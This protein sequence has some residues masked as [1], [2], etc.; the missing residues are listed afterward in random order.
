MVVSIAQKYRD[1]GV[2]LE[3]LVMAGFVGLLEGIDRYDPEKNAK[4]STY[5][6]W[7]IRKNVLEELEDNSATIRYPWYVRKVRR[8]L[9]RAKRETGEELTVSEIQERFDVTEERAKLVKAGMTTR[10]LD[11]DLSKGTDRSL[12]QVIENRK[13]ELPSETALEELKSEELQENLKEEL[14]DRE[15]R[16]IKLYYGL[17]DYYPRTLE[18]VGEVFGLSLERIRQLKENALEKLKNAQGLT[19]IK[20]QGNGT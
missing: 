7:W 13:A 1:K 14:T 20:Q 4:L 18:K 9:K 3:D 6:T 10:S 11:A 12:K 5:A 19:S 2:P 15:R 17:E 8:K 16:I